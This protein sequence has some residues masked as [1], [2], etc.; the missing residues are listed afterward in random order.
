[1]YHW[2]T[3]FHPEYYCSR[4]SHNRTR[5]YSDGCVSAHLRFLYVSPM[6]LYFCFIRFD[7]FLYFPYTS[8]GAYKI[9]LAAESQCPYVCVCGKRRPFQFYLLCF[10]SSFCIWSL[11]SR[12]IKIISR[13]QYS[14]IYAI[15]TRTSYTHSSIHSFALLLW[16]IMYCDES[17][18]WPMR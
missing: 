7:S 6:S 16:I 18:H 14:F 3:E 10:I 9:Y 2:T 1:M 13:L 17:W 4:G 11:V 15:H 8:T 12:S 5:R